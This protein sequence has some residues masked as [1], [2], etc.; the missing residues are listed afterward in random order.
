[1]AKTILETTAA[2]QMTNSLWYKW[3]FQ[4]QKCSGKEINHHDTAAACCRETGHVFKTAHR[5][6]KVFFI[7]NYFSKIIAYDNFDLTAKFSWP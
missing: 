7:K 6:L 5:F 2:Q 3:A 4:C 1:M